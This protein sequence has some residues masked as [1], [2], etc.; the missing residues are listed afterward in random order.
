MSEADDVRH[1][2][3]FK[4]SVRELKSDVG[5]RMLAALEGGAKP[6]YRTLHEAALFFD[7]P[8]VCFHTASADDRESILAN[9]LL[10][11]DE[12]NW[13]EYQRVASQPKGVYLAAEPDLRGLWSHWPKW[14]VWAVDMSGLDWQ[15][16]R[17]NPGCWVVLGPVPVAN[18]TLAHQLGDD[19]A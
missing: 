18:L 16:D 19:G 15:H 4:M 11:G 10:P 1:H 7:P 3:E 9:G 6:D 8:A 14:D 12:R 17:L 2:I 13:N 5:Q